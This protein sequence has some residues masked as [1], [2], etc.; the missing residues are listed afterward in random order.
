MIARLHGSVLDRGPDWL[1]VDVGGVGFQVYA[2]SGTLAGARAGAEITL[3]THLAVRE[4]GMTLYG[5]ATADQQRLFQSL[6]GVSGV[7]PKAA[8]ALLSVFT[9]DELSYAIASGN[10]AALARAPGVGQKLAGR[11]VL[12]LRDKL[13][14]G[15]P[16]AL[17]GE[18]S[19]VV[20]ALQGLGYSQAEALEAVAKSDLPA[21]APVEDRVR[22]ALGYFARARAGG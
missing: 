17:P 20:A 11:I 6:L 2:P 5:F 7:G 19:D 21:D 22:L 3:H 18:E 15:A 14:P 8:L 10:A 16:A 12:D 4:D 1:I 13:A 9:A